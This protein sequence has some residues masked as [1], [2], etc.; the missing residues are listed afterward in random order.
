MAYSA[1]PPAT[2]EDLFENKIRP[3]LADNCYACHTQTKLG[4]L[5]LDSRAALLEG[6]ASGAAIVPGK[7]EESLLIKAVRHTDDDLKMPMGQ[8]LPD[9]QIAALVTWVEQG[10][11]WPEEPEA[12]ITR[13]DDGFQITP[14]H[15]LYIFSGS[16]NP[17]NF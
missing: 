5:R 16:Q 11:P 13:S 2:G 7:P 3:L 12:V 14:R 9:D 8:K 10:A 1:T 6:G 17:C 15:Q 4:G